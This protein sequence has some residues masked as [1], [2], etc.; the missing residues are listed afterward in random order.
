[1]DVPG[2]LAGQEYKYVL[3]NTSVN[4]VLW[5]RD[6]RSRKVVNSAGNSIVYPPTNFNWNGDSYAAP[7]LNGTVIYEMHAGTFNAPSGTPGKFGDA[8]NKLDHLRALGVNAVQVMPIAEFA[9]DLSWGYNPADLHAVESAYGGPDQFKDFVKA[10]HARGIAVILDVVHNHYGPSDNSVWQYDGWSSGGYGGIYFYNVAGKCCTTWGDTRPNFSEPEVRN[11]IKGSITMWLDECHVDGFRWDT[12]NAMIYYDG[13]SLPEAQTL[14]QEINAMMG[15]QYPGKIRIAEDERYGNGFDS[16]WSVGFHNDL[17][18]QLTLTSDASRSMAAVGGLVNF[19]YHTERVIYT[20][21][22]DTVGDLNNNERLP[23]SIDPSDPTSIWARKRS[24]MGA[25]ITLASPG[26]PMLFEGQEMLDDYPFSNYTAMRWDRTNTYRGIVRAY[27][28]LIRL[29]RNLP[30]GTEGLKGANV[31]VYRMDDVNKVLAFHRWSSHGVGDDTVVIANFSAVKWTNNAYQVEFPYNGT[32]YSRFNS[33]STNYSAD[34]GNIGPAQVVASGGAAFVDM[35]M[36]SVQVFSRQPA[37][38]TG[39]ATFDP[40]NPDEC[41]DVTV[42]YDADGGPLSNASPVYLYI[43]HDNWK[44]ILQTNM[45]SGGNG[46]WTYTYSI[47][48]GSAEINCAFNNGAGVWDNNYTANWNL[49]VS[50]CTNGTP[51][52]VL[53]S[54]NPPQGCGNV[55]ISYRPRHGV[56]QDATNIF[57]HIGRNGWQDIL[58]PDPKMTNPAAG[59][60]TFD[61]DIPYDTRRINFVFNNGAGTW[62]NNNGVDYSATVLNCATGEESDITL[63]YGVPVISGDPAAPGDQNNVGDRMDLNREGGRAVRTDLGGFGDLG[64]LYAN[65]DASNL[66]VGA[67]GCNVAGSNNAIIVFLDVDT[68]TENAVNLWGRSGAPQGLDYLHNVW[69]ETP[70]DIAILVGDEYGDGQYPNF[71]LGNGYDFGQGVFYLGAA[72]FPTVP[73]ARL[74]QFDGTGTNATTAADGDGNRLTD[75]WEASIPW[76]SLD[77]AGFH[78]I[79]SCVIAGVVASD[80]TSG[81]NRYLSSNYLG[82]NADNGGNF[83]PAGN[84]GAGY[85]VHL[86]GVPVNLVPSDSDGDGI[87]N[88]W[89]LLY[90]GGKT[91]ATA[92]AFSD[93][94][95]WTDLEEYFA[96]TD[97]FRADSLF[98]D[99]VAVAGSS[100]LQFFMDASV[101]TRFYDVYSRSNLLTGAW[102]PLGLSA[103]GNGGLLTLVITNTAESA[104]YRSG[105]KV[106]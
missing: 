50:N 87:A 4:G 91:N 101:P 77:A 64:L 54:A 19:G 33:D 23:K 57:I 3:T 35:G 100:V 86:W 51:A 28:D 60:W 62:D 89:E 75:R 46:T 79:T 43:A 45:T 98:G 69:F 99:A 103:P 21:S 22:H 24:L 58:S 95:P 90:Y 5:K 63:V 52:A 66:Y 93:G 94:D 16:E 18:Y 71:G 61:Y 37:A 12:P 14:L 53:L 92:H 70:M 59:L 78:A 84:F 42:T 105:V 29:R 44:D 10:C 6:A 49:P 20:E 47:P 85:V 56:L 30:G 36:Y 72:S 65:Y 102:L 34:F 96:G 68:R 9:G 1:V 106:P 76:S 48:D 17:K 8:I 67:V 74:S 40:P 88:G 25:A 32:W 41:V 104:F 80:G 97:P 73:G 81:D 55:V 15:A 31:N 82:V 38:L 26:I 39:V 7:A 13:G 11:F 27:R 2:A 83:D